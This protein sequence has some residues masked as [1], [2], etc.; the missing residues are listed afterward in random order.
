MER[1]K[2]TRQIIIIFFDTIFTPLTRRRDC[3]KSWIDCTYSEQERL[4]NEQER[5]NREQE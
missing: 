4:D 5:L 2:D 1:K 3:A